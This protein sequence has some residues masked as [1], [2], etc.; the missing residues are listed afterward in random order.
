MTKL[1]NLI[2]SFKKKFNQKA[3]KSLRLVW[4]TRAMA[5]ISTSQETLNEL[6]LGTQT[7]QS[8]A[9]KIVCQ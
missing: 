8:D 4:Y 5:A 2:A 3:N 6:K 1:K 9:I 7:C